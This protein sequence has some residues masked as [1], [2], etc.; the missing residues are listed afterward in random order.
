MVWSPRVVG[1]G[2]FSL[3]IQRICRQENSELYIH[4]GFIEVK[5]H[6]ESEGR[7]QDQESELTGG[8]QIFMCL[9]ENWLPFSLRIGQLGLQRISNSQNREG[10]VGWFIPQTVVY[11]PWE[12]WKYSHPNTSLW[13]KGSRKLAPSMLKIKAHWC[14]YS[15][16]PCL[17]AFWDP[18]AS[19]LSSTV[20]SG[21]QGPSSGKTVDINQWYL[22]CH[23]HIT[24]LLM[25]I[26]P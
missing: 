11:L 4:S 26:F 24:S 17:S 6:T 21:F 16:F 22:P 14:T 23:T 1:L 10:E 19:T 7:N 12:V 20:T 5:R 3:L 25:P 9:G 13:Q 15:L 8:A 18:S 2:Y